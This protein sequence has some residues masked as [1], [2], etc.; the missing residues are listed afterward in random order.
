MKNVYHFIGLMVTMG[1]YTVTLNLVANTIGSSALLVTLP[2][3]ICSALFV[4]GIFNQWKR[5]NEVS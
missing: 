3:G 2:L 5:K 1:F 4:D